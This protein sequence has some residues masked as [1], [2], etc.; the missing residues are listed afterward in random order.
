MK[1]ILYLVLV[2]TSLNCFSQERNCGDFRTGEFR[3]VEKDLN[4]KIIR[5]DTLQIEIGLNDKIEIHTSIEWTSDCDYVMTYKKIL[6]YPD[7]VSNVIGEKIYVSILE[8]KDNWYKVYIDGVFYDG[9]I[10]FVKVK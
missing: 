2:V 1:N 6:N 4:Q 8:T 3:Y 7:D 5:N 9:E 10:E